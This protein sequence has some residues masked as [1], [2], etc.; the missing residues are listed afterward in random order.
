M[1]L[2][3]GREKLAEDIFKKW[4][5]EIAIIG[6]ITDTGHL[7]LKW[8]GK[9]I[10]DI[11]V[12]PLVEASPVYT[13]P[14]EE[15]P[16]PMTISATSIPAPKSL[17]SLLKKLL[18][19]PNMASRRWIWEQYDYLVMGQTIHAP[20]GDAAII[21]LPEGKK[22]LAMTTDCTPRYVVQ[23]PETG[24]M[25]ATVECWRN[26]TATG[27]RPLALTNNLNFGNPEDPIIMGQFVGAIKGMGQAASAL[28]FPVVSGNVSFYN[29]TDAKAILPTPVIGGIGVID[30]V[31]RAV[32]LALKATG[33]SLY[34]IG[35]N[36]G[37][38][39]CSV[40]LQ[41][42]EQREE[43]A[44]PPISLEMEIQ[45]GDFIRQAINANLLTASHDIAD[46]GLLIAIAEM[47]LAAKGIGAILAPAPEDIPAHA[48]FF[49][50]DQGRYV[51]T[52]SSA[53]ELESM[54]LE[55]G[56]K[57]VKI[58]TTTPDILKIGSEPPISLETLRNTHEH[59]M[60]NY[61]AG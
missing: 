25:Q 57:F 28:N 16:L 48:W 52:T 38:L 4:Q 26:L 24:G 15:T 60:P 44:P 29:E 17:T 54:A 34:M 3:P 46:G 6:K 27:A 55:K 8:H 21:R 11:P 19:S 32:S 41:E 14:Y 2:K 61:M 10:G 42:I 56:V 1:V 30:D 22:G 50:E 37:W 18:G 40:Y 53:S 31:S 47:A 33:E 36:T 51:I 43:G 13:R 23:H 35:E 9:E 49:G 59:W 45:N 7:L 5:L 39:G 58:G 20:G 12:H